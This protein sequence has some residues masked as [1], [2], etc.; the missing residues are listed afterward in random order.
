MFKDENIRPDKI[1]ERRL[2]LLVSMLLA[3]IIS[4]GFLFAWPSYLRSIILAIFIF[5][6]LSI[7]LTISILQSGETA[8][9]YGGLANEI[10]KNKKICYTIVNTKGKIVLQNELAKSFFKGMPIFKFLENHLVNNDANSHKLKQLQNS[11]KLLKEDTLEVTL[12]FDEKTIFSGQEWYRINLRP[13]SLNNNVSE[14][15]SAFDKKYNIYLL[16]SIENITAEKTMDSIF[17]E[18]R[19]SYYNFLNFMPIGIYLLNRKGKVEYINKTLSLMLNTPKEEILGKDI[20]SFL[21]IISGTEKK[22][23]ANRQPLFH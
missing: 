8:I 16:W 4:I 10:L 5:I 20:S 19:R 11:A 13:I 2:L 3:T 23:N 17:Q 22:L 7:Y 15:S 1:L 14:T 12:T 18:E 9:L 21:P 6:T